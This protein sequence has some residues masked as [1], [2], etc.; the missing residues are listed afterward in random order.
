MDGDEIEAITMDGDEIV[1]VT[2]DGD[3]VWELVVV[4]LYS[5][6]GSGDNEVHKITPEGNN[7]WIYTGHGDNVYAVAVD[8]GLHGAGF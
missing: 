5:Y 1:E 2:M 8:P 3:V 6:A 4:D 7:E